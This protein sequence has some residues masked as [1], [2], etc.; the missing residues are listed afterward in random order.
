MM[1]VE[2]C[3]RDEVAMMVGYCYEDY[4]GV[5]YDNGVGLL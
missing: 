1:T 2:G 4:D 5:C 3:Y